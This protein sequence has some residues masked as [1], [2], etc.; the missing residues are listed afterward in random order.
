MEH[1]AFEE[2]HLQYSKV[3]VV[4]ILYNYVEIILYVPI[5]I[6][7]VAVISNEVW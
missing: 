5:L 3:S 2:M 4:I 7:V 1:G 6:S